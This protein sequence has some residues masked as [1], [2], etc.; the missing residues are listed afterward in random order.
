MG[1]QRRQFGATF[2]WP[3]GIPK[4]ETLFGLHLLEDDRVALVESPLDVV[5]LHQAGVPAVSSFG[6]A[7]SHRQVDL[8]ARNCAVVVLALD[9]DPTGI[10]SAE[11]LQRQLRKRTGVVSWSYAGTK[12]K[13]PGE[14]EDDEELKAAWT[15]SLRLGL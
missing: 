13:D 3:K 7:V 5:R 9:N 4:S 10:A 11:R 8:L 15:R 6:A 1:W 2:N 14:Y 12:A